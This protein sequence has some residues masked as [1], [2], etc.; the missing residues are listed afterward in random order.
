MPLFASAGNMPGGRARKSNQNQNIRRD[1][2]GKTFRMANC[3]GAN[4]PI[5]HLTLGCDKLGGV[6]KL[7]L[8]VEILRK[9]KPLAV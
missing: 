8:A 7:T 4:M 2:H 6:E 3:S 9:S 1:S 5:A